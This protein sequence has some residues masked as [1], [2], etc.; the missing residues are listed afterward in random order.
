VTE[1]TA[2]EPAPSGPPAE[3]QAARTGVEVPRPVKIAARDLD[4][5]ALLSATWLMRARLR[6]LTSAKIGRW[7]AWFFLL[8]FAAGAI[9]LRAMDGRAAGIEGLVVATAHTTAWLCAGFV[10][11]AATNQR[12][13]TDRRDGIEVLAAMRGASTRTLGWARFLA[14]AFEAARVIAIPSIAV[15]ILTTSLSGTAGVALTRATVLLPIAIYA[16]VTGAVLA[17][18]S[19]LSDALRPA[20]GRSFFM[21]IIILPWALFDLLGHPAIS[22][23]G[24]LGRVLSVGLDALGVGGLA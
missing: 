8:A 7:G 16:V 5:R 21:G 1:P 11:L 19:V 18:L 3:A 9:A 22:V 13:L 2:E 20:G 14:T 4:R 23:P 24:L 17:F 10:A 15:G 12:T 6:R